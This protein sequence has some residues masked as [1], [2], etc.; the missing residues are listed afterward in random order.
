MPEQK[1][2]NFGASKSSDLDDKMLQNYQRLYAKIEK[3]FKTPGCRLNYEEVKVKI[4]GGLNKILKNCLGLEITDHGNITDSRGCLY[5]KKTNQP[6]EFEFNVLS[7]GE[8]EVVDIVLDIYLKRDEFNDTIYLIDEPELHLNTGIQQIFFKELANLIPDTCQLWIATHS[9]GF[10]RAIKENFNQ[11][12]DIIYFDSDYSSQAAILKPIEKTR[13]N[14]QKIFGIAL[15][16]MV[17]LMVPQ[18]VVY[19]EGKKEAEP[20]GKEMG[21][22]AKVYNQIFSELEPDVLFIS[23]GGQTEPI[24]NSAIALRILNKATP[25]LKILRLRDK[26]IKKEPTTNEDRLKWISEDPEINRMLKRK[27]IEDYL[28]DY[29]NIIKLLT[30]YKS[31]NLNITYPEITAKELSKIIAEKGAKEALGTIKENFFA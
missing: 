17:K 30:K 12:S 7:S 31:E 19:C 22:D 23:S 25:N 24:K 18:T 20:N 8:K 1:L 14:W 5:F 4:L 21:F 9:I 28:L 27:E 10:L 11:D 6:V 2:N 15:E 26:D 13:E 29:E 3:E 16:D